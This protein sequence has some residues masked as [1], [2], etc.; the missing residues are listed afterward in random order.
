MAEEPRPAVR[1]QKKWRDRLIR[2]VLADV[3]KRA[4][5]FID[6][7]WFVLWAHKTEG[8]AERGCPKRVPKNKSWGRK[9]RPPSCAL[10]ASMDAAV[11]EVAGEWHPTWNQEE[12]WRH[13]QGV[14]ASYGARGIR[15]LVVF[16]DHGPWHTAASVRRRVV[17]H[18]RQA[19]REGG[20]RVLLY[21]LPV[22]APWLM[23]LEPVFGQTKRAVGGEQRRDLG[24][25]QSAVDGRLERRNR[26]LSEHRHH[27]VAS[28]LG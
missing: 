23:P 22:R 8:W 19:K 11:R 20:V 15:Y 18:N 1:V 17:E 2:W 3:A 21:Y 9:E 10:Y 14:I 16:W 26:K 6:E 13:L 7:S 27:P 25:L 5:V 12:T 4:G 24:E 28:Q